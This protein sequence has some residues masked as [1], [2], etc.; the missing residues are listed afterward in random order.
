M[1]KLDSADLK[2]I[3][4]LPP[5]DAVAYLKA[6]GIAVTWDFREMLDAA[7]QRAFT[8]AGI[9]KVDAL[10]A[11]RE[12]LVRALE[13][14]MTYQD[15]VKT[16]GPELEKR[17]LLGRHKLVNP[18][19]GELKTLSPWRLRTIYQT[20][21]QSAYMAGRYAQMK[22]TVE[23]HP[24]WQY[25]A[26][27]DSRT[28][29]AHRALNG[30]TFRHDDP[31]WSAGFYPPLGYNCRCRARPMSE[32]AVKRE[33]IALSSSEGRLS[34]IEVEVGRGDAARPAKVARFETA[35]GQFVATDPGFAHSPAE[36]TKF[37]EQMRQ[38]RLAAFQQRVSRK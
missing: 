5:A 2:A 26:I 3:F 9:L 1:S 14:G 36:A 20:N 21:L 28:R 19:T 6:K 37:L 8:A 10:E 11:I 29:P 12:S 4:R 17:G 13:E 31:I 34:Q 18:E 38:Q 24:Y 32:G 30:R 35:P 22:E 15:W 7:H 25:V 27:M 23:S 33:G 16:I